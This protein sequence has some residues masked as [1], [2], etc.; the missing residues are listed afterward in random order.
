MF[1]TETILYYHDTYKKYP[2]EEVS[3]MT[4]HRPWSDLNKESFW[5]QSDESMIKLNLL[6]SGNLD[7]IYGNIEAQKVL[8]YANFSGL[9]V[10]WCTYDPDYH[11]M[12]IKRHA[13]GFRVPP[14]PEVLD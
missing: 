14:R 2:G 3:R 8:E 1:T 10:Q 12:P 5:R 11:R 6:L 13:E 7:G 4:T 9:D